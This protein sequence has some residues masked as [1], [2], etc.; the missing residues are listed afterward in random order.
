MSVFFRHPRTTQERR[1]NGSR[2]QILRFD[3]FV[4]KCRG[5][6]SFRMLPNSWNDFSRGDAYFRN[7][8]RHRRTQYKQ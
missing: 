8:K 5:R 4:V 2:C 1:A 6:R 3:D 7:W